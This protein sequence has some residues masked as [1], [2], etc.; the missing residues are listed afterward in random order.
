MTNKKMLICPN[1]NRTNVRFRFKKKEFV[2]NLCGSHWD[3]V[4]E[5]KEEAKNERT[6]KV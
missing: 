3:R 6:D 1:C 4:I 2:C 5:P